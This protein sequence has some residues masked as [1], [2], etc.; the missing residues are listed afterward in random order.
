M[1]ETCEWKINPF[2]FKILNL[3]SQAIPVGTIPRYIT[4]T[5]EL[6]DGIICEGSSIMKVKG[7]NIRVAQIKIE[8]VTFSFFLLLIFKVRTPPTT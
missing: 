4:E 7:N 8:P 5:Q 3:N 2:V 1:Y 6:N